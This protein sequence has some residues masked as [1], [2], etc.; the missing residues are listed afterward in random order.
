MTLWAA[1]VAERLEYSRAE[2]LTLGRAVTGLN[3][4]SKAKAIGLIPTI[5]KEPTEK[6][7]RPKPTRR[8]AVVGLLGRQVPVIKDEGRA[9]RDLEGR[10]VRPRRGRA[11]PECKVQGIAPGGHR[12]DAEA[13]SVAQ[14]AGA[15]TRSLCVVRTV[16]AGDPR[17]RGGLG[18]SMRARLGHHRRVIQKRTDQCAPVFANQ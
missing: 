5:E 2:A 8:P 4:Y 18:Q 10:G 12:G 9:A 16:P 11:V 14:T 7:P 1:V 3:A 17:R 13:S 6:K 15:R